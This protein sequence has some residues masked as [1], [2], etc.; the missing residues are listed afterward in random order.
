[1]NIQQITDLV[2]QSRAD[3]NDSLTTAYLIIAELQQ[4][5]AELKGTAAELANEL[6]LTLGLA[7]EY[8]LR[9]GYDNWVTLP[10]EKNPHG[11]CCCCM[12]CGH[13]HDS[14]V[15]EHNRAVEQTA[16][17]RALLAKL[18]PKPEEAEDVNDS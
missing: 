1:M 6:R 2:E 4:E 11:P 18:T 5:T 9:G 10:N 3:G 16:Y 8:A 13:D 14:C 12:V 15:C 17:T 7:G